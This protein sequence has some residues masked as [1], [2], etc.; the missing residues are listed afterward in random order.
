MKISVQPPKTKE[1]LFRPF[2]DKIIVSHESSNLKNEVGLG[3]RPPTQDLVSL[4]NQI[5]EEKNDPL[6]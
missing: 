2:E 4:Q 6:L 5:E 3:K 1:I